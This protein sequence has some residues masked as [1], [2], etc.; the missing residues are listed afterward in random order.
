M[1]CEYGNALYGLREGRKKPM[2]NEKM[3]T[4][5]PQ[6]VA[7][8]G[9]IKEAAELYVLVSACTKEPYVVCDEETFDDQV[10]MFLRMEDAQAKGKK[11]LEEKIPV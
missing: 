4:I 10:L 2:E 9:K 1:K 7:V 6:L 5:D 3:E 8:F 11:L